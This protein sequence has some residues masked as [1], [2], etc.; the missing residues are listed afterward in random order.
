MNQSI[1]NRGKLDKFQMVFNL[2]PIM[3]KDNTTDWG[4]VTNGLV[5]EDAVQFT[6]Q[7]AILPDVDIPAKE[8]SYSGQTLKIS[9]QVRSGYSPIICK[10]IIDNR[11]RNYWL[12][13]QWL[14]K[15]NDAKKSVMDDELTMFLPIPATG[16]LPNYEKKNMWGYKTNI[17]IFPIDEYNKRIC[18]FVF[19]GAFLTYLQG[20]EY[21]FTTAEDM[22]STF[23]FE[24][25]QY[26]INLIE[27]PS[28]N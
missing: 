7:S 13:F 9:S 22:N 26:W 19:R 25:D 28:E 3:K 14:N 8:L 11:F 24:F 4:T 23:K 6:L 18:E 27:E 15:I 21:S 5:N 1:L 17:S 20:F 10:Y 16:N 2:P 12:L